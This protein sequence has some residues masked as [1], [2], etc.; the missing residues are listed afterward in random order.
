MT[1][2]VIPI[3]LGQLAIGL[4]FILMA[5]IASL[6][7]A[8]KLERDLVVGT[9]RAF[10]QL[11]LLGYMLKFIFNLDNAVLVVAVFCFMVFLL[12]LFQWLKWFYLLKLGGN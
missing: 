2:E 10:A 6:W 3:G 8:L 12:Q 7:H 1:P 9:V 4:V 5:G 11:C